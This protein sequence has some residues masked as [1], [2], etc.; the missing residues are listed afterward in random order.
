MTNAFTNRPLLT[1]GLLTLTVLT[2]CQ[3]LPNDRPTPPNPINPFLDT[4]TN[5]SI[6]GKIGIS[7]QTDSGK[8]GGSAFYAWSQQ[9]DRFGIELTGAL[10]LGAT[11]IFYDG[12]NATL[13]NSETGTLTA[14]TPEALLTKATGWRAPLSKLPYWIV[15][16]PAPGDTNSEFDAQKLIKSS[17]C[18][19]NAAFEYEKSA[20]PTRIVITH[21]AGH[22]VVMTIFG[23]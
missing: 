23:R 21:Q 4:A 6:T 2:G 9:N 3:S 13:V 12:V 20:L 1:L 22:R 14:P 18:G 19:W 15:G 11:Q 17:S 5:F 16:K 8:Q 10:G 7:T